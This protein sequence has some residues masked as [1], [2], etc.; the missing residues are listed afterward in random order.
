M[1]ICTEFVPLLEKARV[2]STTDVTDFEP[3]FQA[4]EFCLWAIEI[5]N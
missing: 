5:L 4:T 2:L 3:D 1:L